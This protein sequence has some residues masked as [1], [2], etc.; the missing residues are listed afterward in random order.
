MSKSNSTATEHNYSADNRDMA[1]VNTVSQSNIDDWVD[2][3]DETD[4]PEWADHADAPVVETTVGGSKTMHKPGCGDAPV[5]DCDVGQRDGTE[6]TVKEYAHVA[7]WRDVCGHDVCED[8]I[9]ELE[10]RAD[11]E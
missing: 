4:V 8:Y 7:G 11:G 3:A 5:P 6:W 10:E 1:A 2:P 9:A